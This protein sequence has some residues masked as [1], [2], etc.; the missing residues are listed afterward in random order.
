MAT[1]SLDKKERNPAKS[2]GGDCSCGSWSFPREG[3]FEERAGRRRRA[4]GAEG[5]QL[6]TALHPPVLL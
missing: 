4:G 3:V 6:G 5:A 1:R 2:P